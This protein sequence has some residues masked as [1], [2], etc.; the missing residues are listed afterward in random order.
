VPATGTKPA[1]VTTWLSPTEITQCRKDGQC[2][3]YDEHFT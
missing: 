3:H 1:L 2:F